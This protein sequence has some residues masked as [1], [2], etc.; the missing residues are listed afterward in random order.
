MVVL[1]TTIFCGA[2]VRC[3]LESNKIYLRSSRLYF[4]ILGSIR[5]TAFRIFRMMVV[6]DR[7]LKA[8]ET[9]KI[10]KL[11]IHGDCVYGSY[12]PWFG[13]VG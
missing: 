7:A 11:E 13:W 8:Q 9:V 12:L 4:V 2:A 10:R 3:V 6:W 5:C 1:F